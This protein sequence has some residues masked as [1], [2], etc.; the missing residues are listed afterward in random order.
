[1]GCCGAAT[2]VQSLAG[3]GA[4]PAQEL[5]VRERSIRD[6]PCLIVFVI[7]LIGG[8]SRATPY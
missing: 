3:K 7:F 1:M 6:V 2:R 4:E 8:V 5:P